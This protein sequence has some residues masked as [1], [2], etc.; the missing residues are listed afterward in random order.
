[1]NQ[2]W[3]RLQDRIERPNV[4]AEKSAYELGAIRSS[5]SFS[6]HGGAATGSHLSKEHEDRVGRRFRAQAGRARHDIAIAVR[7][8]DDVSG[9]EVHSRS[10]L[11]RHPA[12]ALRDDVVRHDML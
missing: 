1:M 5:S 9:F 12:S 10:I 7:Y 11:Q 2:P 6:Q 4:T 3:Q 8:D